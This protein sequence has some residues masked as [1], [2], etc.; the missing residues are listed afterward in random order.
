MKMFTSFLIVVMSC[1]LAAIGPQ[2]V[3][4]EAGD[5]SASTVSNQREAD[6]LQLR[7]QL[8]KLESERDSETRSVV[9]DVA[10]VAS[11]GSSSR[12][13]EGSY[14][15]NVVPSV[16]PT[17]GYS[18]SGQQELPYQQFVPS[19]LPANSSWLGQAIPTQVMPIQSAPV[20]VAPPIDYIQPAPIVQQPAPIVQQPAFVQQAPAPQTIVVNIYQQAPAAPAPQN[21]FFPSILAPIYGPPRIQVSAPRRG[22]CLFGRR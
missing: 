12:S 6:I 4:Q 5:D 10:A 17:G 19:A 2:A 13:I 7:K 9:G 16:Y 3:A 1:S 18:A 15:R 21:N 8:M 22:C 11:G 20:N 14:S